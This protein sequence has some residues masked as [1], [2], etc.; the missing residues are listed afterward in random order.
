MLPSVAISTFG[1]ALKLPHLRDWL[2]H[3]SSTY[4][5]HSFLWSLLRRFALVVVL[6]ANLFGCTAWTDPCIVT[7]IGKYTE[8]ASRLTDVGKG[9]VAVQEV[10]KTVEV[11]FTQVQ[12]RNEACELVNRTQTCAIKNGAPTEVQ[13]RL[14]GVLEKSC[15]LLDSPFLGTWKGEWSMVKEPSNGWIPPKQSGTVRVSV[16]ADGKFSGAIT[17]NKLEETATLSG[18]ITTSGSLSGTYLYFPDRREYLE[19]TL[20]ALPNGSLD[21]TLKIPPDAEAA[22]TLSRQ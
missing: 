10:T 11:T 18:T 3:R 20:R 13:T 22:V 19:G 1:N 12:K 2:C 8:Q 14:A 4:R 16:D 21:G 7:P 5:A 6:A 17:N 15:P 9:R